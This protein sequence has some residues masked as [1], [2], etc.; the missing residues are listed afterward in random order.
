M[1]SKRLI[2]FVRSF[3]SGYFKRYSFDFQPVAPPVPQR[4]KR[5][6][7]PSIDTTTHL[8]MTGKKVKVRDTASTITKKSQ[9]GTGNFSF[10]FFGISF[11]MRY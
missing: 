3:F 7:T 2:I 5:R 8:R 11:I 4:Q 10:S 6:R 9:L 1:E